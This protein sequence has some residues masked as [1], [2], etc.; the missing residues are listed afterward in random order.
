VLDYSSLLEYL[1]LK[2]V[3]IHYFLNKEAKMDPIST[4]MLAAL[5]AG[6]TAGAADVGQKAIVDAYEG[7]KTIIKRKFGAQ[8]DL[9]PAISSL[10]NKPD[11]EGRQAT[12][13][14]EVAAA[15]A[16][17]DEEIMAA[18]QALQDMLAAHGD[19]RVQTMLESARSKQTMRGG[20]GVQEQYMD[21]SPESE[22]IME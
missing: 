20:G 5:V 2:R 16:A 7:L 14:E 15:D 13:A 12:L 19:E 8:S 18:V 6:V 3:T 10:E 1:S 22:Q 21:K 11:S 9:A 17:Q 4:V